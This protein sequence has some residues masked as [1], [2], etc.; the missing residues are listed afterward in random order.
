MCIIVCHRGVYLQ[1]AVD[2]THSI[3]FATPFVKSKNLYA[4]ATAR[5]FERQNTDML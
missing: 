2:D 5:L 3:A 1:Y 4:V